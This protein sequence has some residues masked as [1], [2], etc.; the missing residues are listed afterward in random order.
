MN[1]EY[2]NRGLLRRGVRWVLGRLVRARTR[3]EEPYLHSKTIKEISYEKWIAHKGDSTLRVLYPLTDRDIVFDVGG[4]EGQWASDIFAR[5]CCVIH[6]F[7]PVP[8]YAEA[9]SSR[10]ALNE[11]ITV[12]PFALGQENADLSISVDGDASSLLQGGT[13]LITVPVRK[14]SEWFAEAGIQDVALMKINIEGGE[15]ELLTH[16]LD[17]GLIRRVRYFQIQFHDFVPDAEKRMEEILRRLSDTHRPEYRFPF[18]WE[19]WTRKD[20]VA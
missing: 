18:I 12:H 14:Y 7:E 4:Y 16:M 3:N 15:Y 6:V 1:S 8:S 9:I 2:K 11:K 19:G 5:Y 10:F 13:E 17:T 20:G